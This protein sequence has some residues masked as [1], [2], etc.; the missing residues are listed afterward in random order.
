MTTV[1]VTGANRGIGLK[2]AQRYVERGDTVIATA[3]SLDAAADLKAL[4]QSA[5]GRLTLLALDVT[6]EKSCADLGAALA[7]QGLDLLVNNAGALNGYGGIEDPTHTE[8]GWRTV[9]MANVAGPFLVTRACLPGLRASKGRVAIIS[10]AMGS[11]ARAPGGALAYRASKA[12]ATNLARNLATELASDGIAVGAYH[13]G[14]VRTDMGGGTA[15]L[16]VE[17]STEGLVARFDALSLATT[18][19]VEDYQGRA[20]SY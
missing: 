19:V 15:D 14:W 8:D 13:P 17:E 9:L 7:G 20:V 16:S 11:S 2:L 4:A 18:G 5:G 12:A 3:R 10:S 1:L 6:S